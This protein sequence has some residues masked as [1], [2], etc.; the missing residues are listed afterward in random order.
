M[1]TAVRPT[2]AYGGTLRTALC[3]TARHRNA[4]GAN[5]ALEVSVTGRLVEFVVLY[6]RLRVAGAGMQQVD[7]CATRF[8]ARAFARWRYHL[9]SLEVRALVDVV[10]R[11]TSRRRRPAGQQS[12]AGGRRSA[13]PGGPDRDHGSGGGRAGD[14]PLELPRP[15]VVVLARRRLLGARGSSDGARRRQSGGDDRR[16]AG[17][18]LD[19]AAGE[20]Q[21]IVGRARIAART[22]QAVGTTLSWPTRPNSNQPT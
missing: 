11:R 6:E 17:A 4:S 22:W 5:E 3:G 7:R 8:A 1:Y 21:V 2:A 20:R 12:K 15:E 9:A 13:D 14:V 10:G 18:R 19:V 16:L